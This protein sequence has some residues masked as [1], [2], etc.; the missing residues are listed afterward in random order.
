MI[1]V[2]IV[3]ESSQQLSFASWMFDSSSLLYTFKK[4]IL[5]CKK[6]IKPVVNNNIQFQKGLEGIWKVQQGNSFYPQTAVGIV[7]KEK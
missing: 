5:F 2:H 4:I 6:L 1:R 3:S 7:T